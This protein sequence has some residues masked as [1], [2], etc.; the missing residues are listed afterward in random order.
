MGAGNQTRVFW[1]CSQYSEYSLQPLSN[2]L[3]LQ[4]FFVFSSPHTEPVLLRAATHAITGGF[5]FILWPR[6]G[7]WHF[8]SNLNN[9]AV[10]CSCF[11]NGTYLLH[12]R[13]W[14]PD[15][16]ESLVIGNEKQAKKN[17]LSNCFGS[18][19]AKAINLPWSIL[20]PNTTGHKDHRSSQ[21]NEKHI[22]RSLHLPHRRRS[23]HLNA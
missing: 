12:E 2:V 21:P 1:N 7:Q 18:Y 9:P 3:S 11:V 20:S 5:G 10:P 22:S 8:K 6:V 13:K 14:K 15:R 17:K 4:S 16:D 19:D 23:F